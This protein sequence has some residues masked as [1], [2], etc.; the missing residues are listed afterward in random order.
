[1]T[2]S[3]VD[4]R[5][6]VRGGARARRWNGRRASRGRLETPHPYQVVG[7]RREQTL[8]VHPTSAAVAELAQPADRLHPAE[9]LFN[10]FPRALADRVAR[11]ACRARIERATVLLLRDVGRG[12]EGTQRLHEAVR[13]VAFVTADRHA[14]AWQ[15]RDETRRGVA[16]AGAGRRHDAGVDDQSV[17]V[18]HQAFAEIGQ[19]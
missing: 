7:R 18:L 15:A 12:L 17:A 19:L 16:F 3:M 13:V 10:P 5:S 14:S 6:D 2:T 1:M 8:P 4:S 11:M 9:D